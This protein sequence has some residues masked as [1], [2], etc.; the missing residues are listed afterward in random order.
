MP[1][2]QGDECLGVDHVGVVLVEH[3]QKPRGAALGRLL[4]QLCAVDAG[5][6]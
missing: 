5:F 4:R 2:K 3:A 6:A 1:R